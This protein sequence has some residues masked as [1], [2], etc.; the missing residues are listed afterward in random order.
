MSHGGFRVDVDEL[1]RLAG[2]LDEAAQR[3]AGALSRFDRAGG[4]PAD[5]FGALPQARSAHQAYLSRAAEGV[6][7]LRSVHGAFGESLAG[8]VRTCAANYAHAD[9]ESGVADR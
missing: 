7:A 2:R 4:P 5:A 6:N 9:Q 8:G 1:H 3:V